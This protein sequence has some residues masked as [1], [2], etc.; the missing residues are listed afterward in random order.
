MPSVGSG[1][2][3]KFAFVMGGE[4]ESSPRLVNRPDNPKTEAFFCSQKMVNKSDSCGDAIG[5]ATQT[6]RTISEVDS[7]LNKAR[8][9]VLTSSPYVRQELSENIHDTMLALGL[10]LYEQ[11]STIYEEEAV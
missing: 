9:A 8:E 3:R 11:L 2:D 10:A 6:I 7:V 1:N 5:K 4:R